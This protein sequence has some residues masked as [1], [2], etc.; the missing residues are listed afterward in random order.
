VAHVDRVDWS[1]MCACHRGPAFGV[2][3]FFEIILFL[4]KITKLDGKIP[5]LHK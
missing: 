5:K 2:S 3:F 1:A 4:L